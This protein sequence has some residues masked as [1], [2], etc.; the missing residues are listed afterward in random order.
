M[1]HEWEK[2]DHGAKGWY[3]CKRCG[4]RANTGGP[5]PPS[6]TL[7]LSGRNLTCDQEIERKAEARLKEIMNLLHRRDSRTPDIWT[8][9]NSKCGLCTFS[10]R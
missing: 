2:A 4:H 3:R 6:A 8:A 1:N 9:I 10:T 7:L 5:I